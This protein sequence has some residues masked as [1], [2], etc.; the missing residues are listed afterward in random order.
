MD[1]PEMQAKI[2]YKN[3]SIP[4]CKTKTLKNNDHK[5]CI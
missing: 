1:N 5:W 2:A 3:Y 4:P